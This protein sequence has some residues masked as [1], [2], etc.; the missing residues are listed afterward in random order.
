MRQPQPE[1][2]D[3][4]LDLAGCGPSSQACVWTLAPAPGPKREARH[5][6]EALRR[7]GRVAARLRVTAHALAMPAIAT[8]LIQGV[9]L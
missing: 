4:G 3:P 1:N 5:G 7:L 2:N 8:V 6:S 9:V